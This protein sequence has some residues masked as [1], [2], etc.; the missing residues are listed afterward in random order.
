M[1]N[2]AHVQFAAP[3]AVVE[4]DVPACRSRNM[5]SDQIEFCRSAALAAI[6]RSVGV[7]VH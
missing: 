2:V 4:I 3:F 1:R 6:P 7:V 5:T